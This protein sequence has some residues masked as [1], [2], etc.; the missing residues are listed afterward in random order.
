MYLTVPLTSVWNPLGEHPATRAVEM[1][2]AMEYRFGR[3][4]GTGRLLEGAAENV[5]RRWMSS[6]QLSPLPSLSP[7]AWSQPWRSPPRNI[8][9]DI[10]RRKT[11][12]RALG[13]L[14]V[15][16]VIQRPF[17]CVINRKYK[18]DVH[19]YQLYRAHEFPTQDAC[20]VAFFDI[21]AIVLVFYDYHIRDA[22]LPKA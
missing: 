13:Q 7:T 1:Y 18:P 22:T 4:S 10:L 12:W 3:S 8:W 11:T 16:D 6:P 19:K 2:S 9:K 15:A 14:G 5:F 21:N 20:V 17:I